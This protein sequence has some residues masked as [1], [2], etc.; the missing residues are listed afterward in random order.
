MPTS[1]TAWIKTASPEHAE[2]LSNLEK[3]FNRRSQLLVA[4]SGEF[5][6]ELGVPCFFTFR[7]MKDDQHVY[8]SSKPLEVWA[9]VEPTEEQILHRKFRKATRSEKIEI[10]QDFPYI[11]YIL[12]FAPADL[13]Q[14]QS[15]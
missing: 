12:N 13:P 2:F 9:M 8:F 10:P 14:L 5:M 1:K 15:E 11:F 6:T 3:R 7:S 4:K